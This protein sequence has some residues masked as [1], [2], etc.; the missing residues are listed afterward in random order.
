[1]KLLLALFLLMFSNLMAQQNVGFIEDFALAKDRREALKQLI[2]GTEEYYFYHALH[3]QNER[4]IKEYDRILTEWANRFQNSSGRKMIENREALIRYSD[5]PQA[6]LAY[7]KK[8]LSL[9]FNHQQEGKAREANHPSTLDQKLVAWEAFLSDVLGS[10][11]TLQNL[12]DSAF[13]LFLESQPKLSPSEQREL[14]SRVRVPD[15]P[16]LLE[17]ILVDLKSKESKG[18]GEFPIHRAL[19]KAQL[20]KL[21]EGEQK[22][23]HQNVFV[24]TYLSR[25]LP[26]PDENLAAS[27]EVRQAYLDRAWKF[28]ATLSPSFNSLK[29]HVLYQHLVHDRALGRENEK[30]FLTYLALPRNVSYLNPEWR[31]KEPALW[32]QAADLGQD[33]KKITNLP[34]VQGGDEALVKS[35]LLHFL[36]DAGDSKKFAPYLRDSWLRRVFAEAKIIHGI[37]KPAD[38]ASLLSPAEFQEL[39]DRVDIEFDPTSREVYGLNDDVSLKIHLKN[40]PKLI[41]KVF[42]IN[43]LNYYR[44]LGNEV[45]TDIDLD[46]LVANHVEVHEYKDSPQ[47]R[48]ARDFKIPAIDKRR[49]LW[50]IEFIGGGK[51][52]RAVIRKGALGILNQTIA[53]GE[54][55]TVLDE[56]HATVA[57]ASV[58]IGERQYDCDKKGRTLVP[59]SNN[60]GTRNIVVRDSKGFATMAGFVQ[61]DEKYELGAGMHLEQ[62]TLRT[63]GKAKIVIRPTLTVA[64][65]TISLSKC[66]SASLQLSSKNLDGLPVSMSVEDIKLASD[67]EFVHEFRVPDRL[68]SLTA[69]L[70]VKLKIASLGG[71]EIELT[72]SRQFEVNEFL[73]SERVG[74]LYLSKIDGRYRIEFLG[75]N[76]E[77][78]GGQNLTLV[79]H[80]ANF[81]NQRS[82]TLKTTK[83]GAIDLGPLVDITRVQIKEPGGHERS[84]TLEKDRRD[85]VNVITL[86]AGQELK[87]PYVGKFNRREIGLFSLVGGHNLANEFTKLKLNDGSLTASLPA[88]DYRLLLKDSGQEIEILVA[89]GTV[90]GGHVFND[91]RMLELPSRQPSHLKEVRVNGETLEIDVSGVDPLT[92]VHVVA[93]RFLPGFDPFN[94]MRGSQRPGLT[95]GNARY[96]PSLYISGRNLGDE[97]RYVLERRYAQKF[98]GNMLTRPEI[99]LNPWAVRDTETGEEVLADGDKFSRKTVATPAPASAPGAALGKNSKKQSTAAQS[100]SYEFLKNDPV[101]VPN[102]VPG[103][104]GKL[105]IKLDAFGDRQ[106][107]HVLL[108]DPEGATYRSL[109]LPDRSTELRD[110]RL[111]KALD[112]KRHFTE[113]EQVSLLKKG[114]SLKI[115]NLLDSQFEVFDHLGGIHRYFLTLKNDATLREF[116][117]ITNWPALADEEKQS[118]YSKYACH[119][120]SFFLSRKD[121]EFF[122]KVVLPHLASKKDRTF[123]DDYLL[124][125]PLQK[126]FQHHEYSRLNV[127]ERILLS[128]GDPKRLAALTLDLE[129]RL[130]LQTPDLDQSRYWFGAAVGGGAFGNTYAGAK[131]DEVRK[132]LSGFETKPTHNLRALGLADMEEDAE[133]KVADKSIRA[134]YQEKALEE[135]ESLSRRGGRKDAGLDKL[136]DAF[137][138]TAGKDFGLPVEQLYRALEPT[139]E[140]AESN[141][142]HLRIS[143]HT[144]D[145]VGE[146]RFWLDL[147]KHGLKP[148]FGSRHLGEVTG[149]FAEMMLALAFLDLPFV[150]PEHTDKIE[151][152]ALDFTA[153]GNTLFFHREIKEAGMAA[154]RPPLLISQ[155]YY[156]HNDR[157][158]MEDG[159]KVDKFI[160]DE[161]VRGVVYGAQVVVTNP[162]SSRQTLDILTQLPKGA[163]PMLGQ[164]ATA[165]KPVGLEPYSTYRLEIA[166]YFPE[167]GEFTVYPA[168][169]SKAGEVVA[170]ADSLTLKVV[171]EPTTV[172]E[173]SWAWI[174]QWGDEAAVVRYLETENLHA[175]ELNKI[176][177]RVRESAGFFQK[178][179]AILDARGIYHATLQGYSIAHNSKD[180]LAQYLL[181]QQG[182]LDECGVAL[183][184]DLVTVDPI[185]RRN[186]EHLEYKPLINNRA[187][188][189]GGENRILNPVIR[190]QYQNFLKVLSQQKS[191]DDIDRLAATYFLFLQDRVGEALVHLGKV[192]PG[193]LESKMQFDY[194]Q[195]YAAFYQ[196]DLGK[197]RQIAGKYADYPVDRWREHFADISAQISE[198]EGEAPEVIEEGNREQEQQ[199]AAAREPALDLAVEGT[200]ATL[201]HRNVEEVIVNYYEM[202]LEFLFSTNPFVSSGTSRFAIIQPN[203]SVKL[204]LA[205]GKKETS[206]QLPVE[207]QASNVIV[208]VLGG[209]KR[210]SKVVYA[211]NLKA[212]LSERM[213]LLTVRHGESGKALPKVYVK[214]YASTDQGVKFFKDGYTDFRGKFDFA[215]VST[216][217]L[218]Q[219]KSFSILVMSEENGATVLEASVPQ[220]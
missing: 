8:E 52:S 171:N 51:S 151:D 149:N 101:F 5:D 86:A 210:T 3:F 154:K 25:L 137:G 119:E 61:H 44:N 67:R 198:I 118:N 176:A 188:A 164:R 37:G 89:Q 24:E 49:G 161:F 135:L 93:T 107:V 53:G 31:E 165:T 94:S 200:K 48:I 148:D 111:L 133:G 126:Y 117:F 19:T 11:T 201:D 20:E 136:A 68:T 85:H 132:S 56:K 220:R 104:D 186:Y 202:D 158:R 147:A 162:T 69:T 128:Q 170:H 78:L 190:G 168:H 211:N 131:V 140:W 90:T 73:G 81:K 79:V 216:T 35:Y 134:E 138:A 177:W 27:P 15:L 75:R 96:L 30:R 21:L 145:L 205:K 130:A 152:G 72:S 150:A 192:A 187:H 102:L 215:S 183:E 98:P 64:G 4:E 42:E 60:P 47:L 36:K 114:E 39:K 71:K 144:Y 99:L 199:A 208:E 213:G 204:K 217:G 173:T 113:Q 38:W 50:V 129:N 181:M 194:F 77:P 29:A 106:H 76:G 122:K 2:P 146:N 123:M 172:D 159:Q 26:G 58:W 191:L 139:K 206:F 185:N 203:K 54:L 103:M 92:R 115:P 196:A 141:Y 97:L 116:S 179:L 163:I 142:Y 9:N 189:L 80:H 209:G 112:Q 91:T 109:S 84:W 178:A 65:E 160:T 219:I 218:G 155:S 127:V 16:G 23:I 95:T 120:L 195:A 153:G 180:H 33:F 34:S 70:R 10:S 207:Y 166:F 214:V 167:A 28:V 32:R 66:E 110:L 13:F 212:T 169:L 88:G 174:S 121:P 40:V 59:F 193:N 12:D 17:L 83:V 46:G 1:M 45:S 108:V 7:L 55:I 22:L 125:K 124:G 6:T 18:F 184:C 197:A 175:I 156:Q 100:T 14:L 43:T 143:Q 87:V 105:T 74:D 82:F 157:F 41:V 63:G 182:F 62:E 57:G